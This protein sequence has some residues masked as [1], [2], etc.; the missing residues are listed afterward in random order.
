MIIRDFKLSDL[1]DVLR[2]EFSEFK[3]P[4]PVDILIQLYNCGAGFLVAEVAQKIIGYIIFWI[5]DGFGHIIVIA[6]DSNY[7]SMHIGS[8]LLEKA[9][10]L[11]KRNNINVV[12]LEVRKSN[13]RAIKF[14]QKNGFVQIAEEDNYYGDGESAIIMQYSNHNN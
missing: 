11:F 1:D 13:I 9:V 8:V 2:I 4:Y 10:Y 5:K 6:V 3:D 7:Q 14:Y 12:R